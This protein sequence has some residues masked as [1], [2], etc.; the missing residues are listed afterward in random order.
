M[1]PLIFPHLKQTSPAAAGAGGDEVPRGGQS[2]Q[3]ASGS[4]S[5]GDGKRTLGRCL[6]SWR[7]SLFLRGWGIYRSYIYIHVVRIWYVYIT[8]IYIYYIR[9]DTRIEYWLKGTFLDILCGLRV[10]LLWLLHTSIHWKHWN[11]HWSPTWLWAG[12]NCTWT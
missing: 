7:V 11:L 2:Q 12:R 5:P 8:Y 10:R 6:E 9:M 3:D 4:D 1:V